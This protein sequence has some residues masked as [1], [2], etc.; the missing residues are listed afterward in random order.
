MDEEDLANP[1]GSM[2]SHFSVSTIIVS[3]VFG[4]IGI[5]VWRHG[6]KTSNYKVIFTAIAMMI[7]PMFTSG[8]IMDWAV[9]IG[10]CWLAYYF[11]SN[12]N[13]TG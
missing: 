7:Y 2:L 3:F 5:Y 11:D 9:G 6:K 8:W 4:V 1:L 12:A 10:L 13:L